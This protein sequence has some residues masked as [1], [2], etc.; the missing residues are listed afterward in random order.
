MATAPF[1][2]SELS[3]TNG[4]TLSVDDKVSYT[5]VAGRSAYKMCT[6]APSVS[7]RYITV[8]VALINVPSNVTVV[9]SLANTG[10]HNSIK[11]I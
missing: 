9:L 6:V 11:L 8:K 1:Y 4:A 5:Y 10:V 3:S 2:T 7:V